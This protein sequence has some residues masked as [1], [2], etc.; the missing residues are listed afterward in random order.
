MDD[1]SVKKF[2]QMLTHSFDVLWMYRSRF[3]LEWCFVTEFY[4]VFNFVG[5]PEIALM[6]Y[7][8]VWH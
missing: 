8:H 1:F 3:V 5:A 4:V 2:L 7:K 6:L